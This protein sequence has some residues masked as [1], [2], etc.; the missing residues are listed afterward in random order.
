MAANGG[1]GTEECPFKPR[2]SLPGVASSVSARLGT[3]SSWL[4]Q[5]NAGL[6][7]ELRY[8]PVRG[9]FLEPHY[10]MHCSR[11]IYRSEKYPR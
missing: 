6:E 10:Q 3:F 1:F 9:R 8:V 2:E 7:G 11:T 5:L 4:Y